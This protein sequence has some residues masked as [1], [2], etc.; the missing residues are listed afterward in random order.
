MNTASTTDAYIIDH[1]VY[2]MY[3]YSKEET[4]IGNISPKEKC[5]P[6]MMSCEILKQNLIPVFGSKG[7]VILYNVGLVNF[8]YI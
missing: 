1:I 5:I 4:L 3:M 8:T 6:I 7:L 2:N